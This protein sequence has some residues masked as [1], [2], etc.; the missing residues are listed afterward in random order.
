MN[1]VIRTTKVERPNFTLSV[2][3]FDCGDG[4][5]S[6]TFGMVQCNVEELDQI[7]SESYKRAE[8]TRDI[9]KQIEFHPVL[10]RKEFT[11]AAVAILLPM[12]WL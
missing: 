1:S 7:H 8:A 2:E 3:T 10:Q 4:E 6:T 5:I 9:L 11:K 12:A